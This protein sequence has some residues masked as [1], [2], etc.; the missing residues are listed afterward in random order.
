MINLTFKSILLATSLFIAVP[1][2][3]AHGSLE[4]EH[5]GIVKEKHDLVFELVKM[6]GKVNLY[7]RDHGE[8]VD[9]KSVDGS[10]TVLSSGKKQDI[11]LQYVSGN[12]LVAKADI[13][14][15]AKLLVKVK[16][17]GHHAITVRYAF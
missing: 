2:A 10:I 5:G 6:D 15:G 12:Q 13:E 3:L 16:M 4:P 9:A 8:P 14:K 17:K 7:L 11:A 1:F